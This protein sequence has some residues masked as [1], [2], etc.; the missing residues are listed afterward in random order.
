MYTIGMVNFPAK[1]EPFRPNEFLFYMAHFP[2]EPSF[3]VDISEFYYQKIEAIT[4]FKSQLSN[5]AIKG[6]DTNISQP[7]FLRR[8][9]RFLIRD[10][11]SS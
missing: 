8:S 5:P 3:I 10:S 6:L 11:S 4:C 1:G 7:D 2:F 9:T